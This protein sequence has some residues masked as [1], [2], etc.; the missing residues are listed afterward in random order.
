[1]I[2]IC[3]PGNL[4]MP[5]AIAALEAGEHV[6]CEKPL[7][8][9]LQEA[10]EMLR[11]S[12]EAEGKTMVAYNYRRV[13]AVALARQLIE[14]GRIGQIYHWR[15]VYLQDWIIDPDFPMVWR[16]EKD[17]AGSGAARGFE[18]AHYRSGAASRGRY[19]FCRSRRHDVY[20]RAPARGIDRCI[21]GRNGR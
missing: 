19:S 10:M 18:C 3:T 5:M 20:Q 16:F 11:A 9:N 21:A 15:A 12:E 8:N 4:H 17:K 2:D 14:E 7:A 13:P 1:M 6:I